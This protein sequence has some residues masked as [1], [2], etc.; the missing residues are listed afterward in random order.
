[1]YT[2]LSIVF[3]LP[4]LLMGFSS[5]SAQTTQPAPTYYI[6]CNGNDANLG[7]SPTSA[8]KSIA[9]ANNAPLVAGGKLLFKRGCVW[10]VSFPTRFTAKWS[11][12]QENPITI[13]DYGVGDK[14]VIRSDAKLSSEYETNVWITGNNQ[15][16]ENIKTDTINPHQDASCLNDD[17]T[18]ARQGWYVGFTIQGDFNVLQNIEAEHMALGVFTDDSSNN[19]KLLNS[20]FHDLDTFTRIYHSGGALGATGVFL[21]GTDNEY[22]YNLFEKNNAQCTDS[23]GTVYNYSAPFEVYNANR[24]YTHHNKAYGHRKHFEMGKSATF[25]ASTDNV[26]AYNLFVSDRARAVGIN[27]HGN[28]IF[29]PINRTQIYNNTVVFTGLNSQA[30]VSGSDSIVKNNIFVA[31]WKAAFY[32][33]SVVESNNL[34]WDFKATSDTTPDPCVQFSGGGCLSLTTINDLNPLFV[35]GVV[36][37]GDYHLVQSSPGV[38]QGVII[39]T[40]DNLLTTILSRDLDSNQVPQST[41]VDLGAYEFQTTQP[42]PIMTPIPTAAVVSGDANGDGNVDEADYQI[43]LVNYGVTS[44]NGA[45]EG[46]FNNDTLVNGIDYAIWRKAYL[47]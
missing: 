22:A 36:L 6:D 7:T 20:Y 34:Y 33:N 11:G 21:H 19:N 46:D 30:I 16:I 2:F 23:V 8:W 12:T 39:S 29:G 32:N 31:E 9:K 41:G 3:L 47:L 37:G 35:N 13:A 24:T 44:S 25:P 5:A 4:L 40:S 15:I 43:W 1:L 42:T 14:P 27:I 45:S 26:L 10:T 38:N 17:Q 28:D 18:P